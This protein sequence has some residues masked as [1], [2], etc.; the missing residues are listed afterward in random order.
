MLHSL[1]FGPLGAQEAMLRGNTVSMT[2]SVSAE[3]L[4]HGAT[5]QARPSAKRKHTAGELQLTSYLHGCPT[6]E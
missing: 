2:K 4:K 1:I 6:L 3:A 5:S